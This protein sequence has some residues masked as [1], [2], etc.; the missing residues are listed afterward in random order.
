MITLIAAI[1][2]NRE[3]GLN[4]QLLWNLPED[5]QHFKN[6]TLGKTVLMGANTCASI[7]RKLPSRRSVVVTSR[8]V[9]T[10]LCDKVYSSLSQALEEE[11]QIDELV[12]IGGQQIYQ[13]TIDLA[14]K[15]VITKVDHQYV[16]D[17]YFP[18]IDS[19]W[20]VVKS[21]PMTNSQNLP[22]TIIEYC[23]NEK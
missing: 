2:R 4:N 23:R 19:R 15:L 8:H 21:T 7:G 12:I 10:N 20:H 14:D 1:G 5:L 6:Y 18:I 9:L 11:K 22:I 3:I 13:S 17:A 16:A